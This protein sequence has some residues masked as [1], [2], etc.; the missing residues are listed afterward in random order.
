MRT[1]FAT[2]ILGAVLAGSLAVAQDKSSERLEPVFR[3]RPAGELRTELRRLW[4][5]PLAATRHSIL[6]SMAGLP[7]AGLAHRNLLK[8]Q[9]ELSLFFRAHL[10][11]ETSKQLAEL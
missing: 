11:V 7:D 9:D 6:S 8:R 3:E 1:F 10:G 2:A 4:S 5:K